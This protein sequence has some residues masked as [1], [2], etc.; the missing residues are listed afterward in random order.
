MSRYS[1]T[2]AERLVLQRFG[3]A[4]RH[5]LGKAPLYSAKGSKLRGDDELMLDRCYTGE[6]ELPERSVQKEWFR[7]GATGALS[8][9]ASFREGGMRLAMRRKALRF[10]QQKKGPSP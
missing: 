7:T 10:E 1:V 9:R 8:T 3:N 5:W 6:H 2:R 4:L